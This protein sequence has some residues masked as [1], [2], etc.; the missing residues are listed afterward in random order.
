MISDTPQSRQKSPSLLPC[1][2]HT[3]RKVCK[4]FAILSLETIVTKMISVFVAE[5]WEELSRKGYKISQPIPG[6]AHI[7]PP[8]GYRTEIRLKRLPSYARYLR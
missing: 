4:E 6:L 7:T 2:D 1:S 3:P 5:A 8:T